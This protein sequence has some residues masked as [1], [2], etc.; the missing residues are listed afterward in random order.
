M[1]KLDYAKMDFV[2]LIDLIR[3]CQVELRN[4]GTIT[5]AYNVAVCRKG[6]RTIL[7][8]YKNSKEKGMKK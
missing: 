8:D 3:D 2:E 7:I 5:R 4:R 6:F 1:I